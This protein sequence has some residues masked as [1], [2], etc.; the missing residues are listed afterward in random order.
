[1]INAC[2]IPVL[3]QGDGGDMTQLIAWGILITLSV[4][5]GLFKKKKDGE[6]QAPPPKKAPRERAETTRARMP[7]APP[8]APMPPTR[9]QPPGRPPVIARPGTPPQ[10]PAP[11]PVPPRVR[12]DRPRPTLARPRPTPVEEVVDVVEIEAVDVEETPPMPPASKPVAPTSDAVP[13]RLR[14][15]LRNRNAIRTAFV[16]TEV[17]RPPIA[18][19]DNTDT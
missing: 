3:A 14:R 15:L 4:L 1:M 18:L 17:L 2:Y 5:G 6:Q 8:R 13:S 19:R 10:R 11:R 9:P 12:V 16:M 7:D